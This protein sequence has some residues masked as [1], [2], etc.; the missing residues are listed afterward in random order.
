M[1]ILGAGTAGTMMANHLIK[2]LDKSEWQIT[3]VDQYQSHYYQPGFLFVPFGIYKPEDVKRTIDEFL[4]K[5]I[6]LVREKIDRI[7]NENDTV[8][9]ENNQT[10]KYD[11]LIYC[12]RLQN[13]TA[14]STRYE[15]RLLV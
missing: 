13:C 4:P 11:L 14:G 2:H 10:L 7:D 6:K 5:G 3:L 9:L 15:R 12:Y 1:V 8:L